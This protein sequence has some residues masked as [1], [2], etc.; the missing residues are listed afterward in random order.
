MI[1]CREVAE[2]VNGEMIEQKIELRLALAPA[3]PR[4]QTAPVE[5]QQVLVNLLLNA[6]QAMKNTPSEL[7]HIDIETRCGEGAVSVSVRDHGC[8]I[9]VEQLGKIFTAFHTTKSSGLGMGLAICRRLIEAHGGRI[10][11]GNHEAGGARFSFSLPALV[12][13]PMA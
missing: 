7:R 4:V 1:S 5:V 9:P 13:Q 12:K 6:A 10:E 11:A 2:F 3:L 8:G